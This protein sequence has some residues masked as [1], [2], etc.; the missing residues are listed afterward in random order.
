MSGWESYYKT[1]GDEEA[2]EEQEENL[3]ASGDYKYSGRDSLIFLV[4]ASKAMFESQS[5][6][7]LT[8]FDMSIQC[9]QSVYISKIISSDRDL[10]AVVFYG[11]EK[12]K[13]SVNFKNIYVLQE[14]DN[15]G[16]K[17]ILE[18]DQFKG[19]Q[20]QKRFQDLMGHGSDYSLSEVLWVCANLFSDVQFKMSHKRIMLFTNEDNPHGNDSAKA[21]RAR[22]KAGDLRDTGIFLDLMHLKKPGGFDISLFYRDIISIAED[23][24]L[25]V[26]FEESSKL[27]DLLRKVRAKETRKRALSRLKLKLNKDIVIS[28]GIYNLV[29]KALKPPPIK[30]YRET[31]EPVKTKTRTFNTSTGGLLLPSDTKR[32]QIYGSRQIILEKEETEELKRFDD[33]GLMLMGF[34]PLVLLKKHHYL[35]PSLF[36]YPEE[37]LVIG[38]STLFSALLIK[39]LEKEVAALCRYTPR[40]NIPPYFVALVPQEEELDDQKIQVTPPGFQLVFLPFADDKRKMP[41]TEKI[42]ATSE[43]VDKMKAIVEKLRFT[44]RSDSFENPVLQ[45]HFRNLEALALDL[46]EPEQAVDLTLP[47]VEA[48][49][50][51]LGSLVDEFK[52]LV[53]PPDYNPEGKVTKR[54]HDNEGSGSKRPKVEYSEEELKTHI[55]KGTLGK[56]TVPMLKEACRAYGLKSGL[57]KQEL[58]EALTKHFQD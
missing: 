51:R 6:N 36:V 33:P 2:E 53:Y 27:E 20:G 5:E 50:K 48:M 37:S 3:E 58:L 43:Q 10:L 30:L 21:S 32:S 52:E 54:K 49:N 47:K 39:C 13:N 44:Y 28:V 25:R 34:K 46:M 4:D 31:N 26:H 8:P 22:T 23:E 9:I 14:L 38:S 24:D 41:F 1:E 57:K 19:Q 56:F 17:R 18:L 29:Q 45:Q 55:S 7:E 40:R 16:A 12:D 15:P 35:R 11:T 42:M